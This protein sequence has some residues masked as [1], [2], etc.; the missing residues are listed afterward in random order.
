MDENTDNENEELEIPLGRE[1][2]FEDIELP[3]FYNDNFMTRTPDC[4]IINSDYGGEFF[5]SKV[6]TTIMSFG[7]VFGHGSLLFLFFLPKEQMLWIFFIFF[8]NMSLF[9][10][11]FACANIKTQFIFSNDG[12]NV[13]SKQGSLFIPREDIKDIYIKEVEE[14]REPSYKVYHIYLNYFIIITFKKKVYIPYPK[15]YKDDI[16]FLNEYKFKDSKT[17]KENKNKVFV[18]YLVQEMKKALNF[19]RNEENVEDLEEKKSIVSLK[20]ISS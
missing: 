10:W 5:P 3:K 2:K 15:E 20:K 13:H 18:S 12:L 7:V 6:K 19:S 14:T 1:I 9:W 16:L 8:F 4:F 17:L 11:A